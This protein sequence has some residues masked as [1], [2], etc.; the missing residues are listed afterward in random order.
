MYLNNC[1][2]I[3]RYFSSSFNFVPK[4][5]P[6]SQEAL[7]EVQKFVKC[8]QRILI[9][10]G[11]GISTE[12]GIPDYRSED[13]GLY[14]TSNKRPVQIKDFMES[15]KVRQRYWARNF[16]GWPRF[17][18]FLPNQSHKIIADWESRGKVSCVVTQNVDGLH[19]KA[20]SKNVIEL[21][22]TA[23]KI[24]C[25]SC[26]YTITRHKFQNELSLYNDYISLKPLSIRPDGDVEISLEEVNKFHVPECPNCGGILKP[27][28]V[29]FGDNVPKERVE[30][31]K[32]ELASSDALLVIGSSL[33]VFSA[34]RFVLMSAESKIP[35]GIINIGVTR[36]DKLSSFRIPARCGEVLPLVTVS[37]VN[38]IDESNTL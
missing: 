2:Y 36:G 12:S 16:I 17:S 29:F 13:V 25:V 24:G 10:S 30:R 27:F 7:E 5:L 15:S 38:Q 3:S 11:A 20:G 37:D 19:F 32:S 26:S 6:C 33:S 22:G 9:L 28:I 23:F 4:H 14:A 31:V 1:M 21:H 8:H 18:S 34:Y 35:I